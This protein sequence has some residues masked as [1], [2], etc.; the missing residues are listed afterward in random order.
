M[1]LEMKRSGWV[2]FVF[3]VILFLSF[4]A[5]ASDEGL[6]AW[7][8]F[9][10]VKN[11]ITVDKIGGIQDVLEGSYKRTKGIVGSALKMNGYSTCIRRKAQESP[12]W[13]SLPCGWL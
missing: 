8:D 4:A 1:E 6:V 2:L 11:N 12:C 5:M 9:E 7:W 3:T 13:L 10:Q